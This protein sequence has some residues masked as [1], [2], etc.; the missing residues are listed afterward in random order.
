MILTLKLKNYND[1]S[2]QTYLK[3]NKK[4]DKCGGAVILDVKDYAEEFKS[5]VNN[6]EN[7][8]HLL[9][10]TTAAILKILCLKCCLRDINS[11]V[12]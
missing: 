11:Q 1:Q 7:Y 2:I 9:K 5:L 12:T 10:V 4:A 8:K 6:N 3:V